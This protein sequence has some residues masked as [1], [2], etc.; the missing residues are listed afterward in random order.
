[1]AAYKIKRSV[2][3]NG[4]LKWIT[5]NTE[6][7]YAEKLTAAFGMINSADDKEKHSFKE[8]AQTWFELYSKPNIASVTQQTY[9]RQ[10]NRY[11]VPTFA[12]KALE[13]ISV[14]D[15]QALFNV[16][17]GAKATKEKAYMVLKM[18]LDAAV[19]DGYIERNPAK[20]KKL[21]ING[22]AS[23]PTKV[24]SLESMKYIV[25]HIDC[26]R[27]ES[28]RAYIALQA[29]HPLRLEEVLGLK[30]A[31]IDMKTMTISI[32]R[33]VTHP[34]RN[35]PEIKAP[36]TEASNRVIGL[37]AIAAKHLTPGKPSDYVIG[38]ENPLSYTQLR[39]MCER[40]Q[41]DIQFD[42]KITPIR[43]RTTVLTDIYANSKDVKLAQAAAGHTTAAMTLK[44]YIKGRDSATQT[45]SVIDAAYA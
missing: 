37:S 11:L 32:H 15:I 41:K 1:M 21:R 20:S 13:D 36:K 12:D 7:E 38:G 34:T 28:D 35:Q 42:E 16:M 25:S 18:I 19:E 10:I 23:E 44:H 3:I 26:I 4:K 22:Q 30:W 31:D 6:Q 43:F 9:K 17:S 5:A 29:L 40:I 2:M 24:Y 33:A 39:R 14:D 27:S 45:A 8:F